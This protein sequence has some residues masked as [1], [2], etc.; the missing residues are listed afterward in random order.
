M[1]AQ[2]Q[3]PGGWTQL[4]KP[5]PKEE[6]IFKETTSH[7]LGVKY[8]ALEVRSQVVEGV[9]YQYVANQQIVGS[10]LVRRVQVDIHAPLK[11]EPV[12]TG[13]KPLLLG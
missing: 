1:T 12:I 9:D 11:G 7:L 2:V 13:I 6:A 4:H 5:D 8:Q 10:E 3:I